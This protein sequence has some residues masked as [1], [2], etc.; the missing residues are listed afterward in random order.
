MDLKYTTRMLL[1][2]FKLSLNI[3]LHETKIPIPV[4]HVVQTKPPLLCGNV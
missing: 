4:N 3:R 1:K 2:I